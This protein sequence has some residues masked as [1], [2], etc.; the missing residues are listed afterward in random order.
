[1]VKGLALAWEPVLPV[2]GVEITDAEFF[3]SA[4][5]VAVVLSSSAG[6]DGLTRSRARPSE[7]Y[8]ALVACPCTIPAGIA[9]IR[10]KAKRILRG[11]V[12][13]VIC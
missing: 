7:R 11:C 5:V 4:D 3:D 1:M 6:F 8:N 2:V 9:R 10:N 13:C 12:W